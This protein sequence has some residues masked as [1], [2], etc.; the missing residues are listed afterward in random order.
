[1]GPRIEQTGFYH[2]FQQA[3]AWFF[4]GL[5]EIA[6]KNNIMVHRLEFFDLFGKVLN[7]GLSW[8]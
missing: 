6:S 3:G 1:M 4:R 7:E 2:K 5:I 8:M